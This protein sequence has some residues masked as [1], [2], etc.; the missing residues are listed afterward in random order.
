MSETEKKGY[1]NVEELVEAAYEYLESHLVSGERWGMNYRFYK[2]ANTKYGAYQWL[3]DSAFH[4]M[5][6][7]HRTPENAIKDLRSMLQFQQPNGFIPEMIFWSEKSFLDKLGDRFLGYSNPKYTD[8]SQM[9]ML[10]YSLR[11]I[12]NST[13]D[14]DLLKELLPKLVH[15][16]EWWDNERD[17]DGDGLISIIH[18]WESGLDA[19]PLYDEP[20]GVKEPGFKQLYPK[21]L[22]LLRTYRKKAKWDQKVILQKGWFNVEDVGVC[23]IYADNWDVLGTLAEEYDNIIAQKCHTKSK[24]YRERILSKC[25]NEE[26]NQFISYYHK[27]DEEFPI[28]KETIQSLFPLVF[29]DLPKDIE[30]KLVAKLRDPNKFGTKYPIPT[31][32]V[33]ESEF[34]PLDSRLMWRGPTWPNTNVFVMEGLLKQGENEL[35]NEILDKWI[36]MHLNNGI[37]EYHNPLTGEAEGQEGLGMANSI[38]HILHKMNRV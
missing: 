14:L 30:Q 9:P 1:R 19:S 38:V 21:F 27:E 25:W 22:K 35:A 18:G 20:Y 34:N 2:P 16:Q 8:I 4:M 33:S 36:E 37:Y 15:Y 6:W 3:W 32:A 10:A 31:T 17:P 23:A 28:Y 5:I 29:T 11:E 7:S 13:K 12:W 26:H 24:E